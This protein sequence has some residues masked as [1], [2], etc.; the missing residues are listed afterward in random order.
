MIGPVIAAGGLALYARPGIGGASRRVADGKI[1][2]VNHLGPEV[3]RLGGALSSIR[4][5]RARAA[6]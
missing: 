5:C 6:S 2:V 1:V 4:A 3:D